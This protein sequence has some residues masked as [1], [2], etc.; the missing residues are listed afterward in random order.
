M[1]PGFIF[2]G[3]FLNND[4]KRGLFFERKEKSLNLFLSILVALLFLFSEVILFIL[5]LSLF[6]NLLNIEKTINNTNS[7]YSENSQQI[8][9]KK[10]IYYNSSLNEFYNNNKFNLTS[11]LKNNE[12]HKSLLL[13]KSNSVD[14]ISTIFNIF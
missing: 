7:R 13:P 4:S 14:F 1:R 12:C 8:R 9:K 6:L 5:F 11:S 3:A 10:I 2:S